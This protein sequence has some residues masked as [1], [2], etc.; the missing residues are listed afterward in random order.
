MNWKRPWGVTLI[1]YFY[2]FSVLILMITLITNSTESTD[3][4]I[5][6]GLPNI[7]ENAVKVLVILIYLTMIY[8]YLKLKKWGY[9]ILM[10][11]S[12]YLLLRNIIIFQ[13]DSP[14][15][16]YSSMIVSIIFYSTIIIYTLIKREYFYVKY[17][18]S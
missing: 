13:E 5:R 15:L 12:F 3:L 8:G 2:I 10:T 17:I 4:A 9:W 14:Q 11:N 18:R 6:F 16:S 7:S 1:G